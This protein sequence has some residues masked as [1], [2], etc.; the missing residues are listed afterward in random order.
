MQ[1][2]GYMENKKSLNIILTYLCNNNCKYCFAPKLKF[3]IDIPEAFFMSI[4]NFSFIMDY[5]KK[6]KIRDVRLLGG[7][8]FLHPE[9]EKIFNEI[10]DRKYF[11]HITIFTNGMFDSKIRRILLKLRNS[12]AINLVVNLNHP[13]DYDK[14]NY[15]L[16]QNNIEFLKDN[17]LDL[18]L[19]YNIYKENFDYSPIL[20]TCKTFGIRRL[21]VCI[22][23]PDSSNNNLILDLKQRKKIG[24]RLFSLYMDALDK[25]LKVLFDCVISPC[26][27]T[28]S[29]LGKIVKKNAYSFDG[30]GICSPALDV[31]PSLKVYRCFAT[32]KIAIANLRDF[33]KIEDLY[34]Y[35]VDKVDNLKWH[36]VNEECKNCVYFKS[37]LCQGDC[38]G[39]RQEE[40]IAIKSD[41]ESSSKYFEIAREELRSKHYDNAI[42]DFEQGLALWHYDISAISDYIFALL[43][44]NQI[45]K[46]A[47]K[48]AD[49]EDAL[50]NDKTGLAPI[51][52]AF[53]YESQ[54][55]Y[56]DAI[57]A[58]R[59][60]LNFVDGIKKQELLKQIKKAKENLKETKQY[61]KK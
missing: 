5:L 16:V 27:F 49:F 53:L 44:T 17:G 12:I 30:F 56:N 31:D 15:D 9:I 47:L 52:K 19:S 36:V 23:N 59:D 41:V 40:M 38:I 11:K 14:G 26:I 51:V 1:T 21:R 29:E 43:R 8:P 25:G 61:G 54:G 18:S 55:K 45:E 24:K 4:E 20:K 60:A 35:F 3:N 50:L 28:D 7:E 58:Y 57:M 10:I 42:M 46:A 22:A 33:A 13:S 39:F 48:F 37:G 2:K 32:N 34:Y 6:N